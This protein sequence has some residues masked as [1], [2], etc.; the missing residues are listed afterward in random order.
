[1][2]RGLPSAS[3]LRPFDSEFTLH[4]AGRG[5]EQQARALSLPILLPLGTTA[6]WE[7]NTALVWKAGVR[8]GNST[9]AGQGTRRASKAI[10]YCMWYRFSSAGSPPQASLSERRVETASLSWKG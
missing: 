5:Y 8:S 4:P 9:V 2:R 3:T 7:K 10:H 1:M 6:P